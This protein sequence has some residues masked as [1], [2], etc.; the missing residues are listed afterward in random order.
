[1]EFCHKIIEVTG[2]PGSGKTTFVKAV[3]P[4]GI[5]LSG[6]MPQSYG[7]AK[8]ILCSILLSGYAVATGK[9][10]LRQLWWL[11]KRSAAYDETLFNRMNALRNSLTK[12]GHGVFTARTQET[13]VID[14]SISHIPFILGLEKAEIETFVDL[15][16]PHLSEK[17]II[18]IET[19][20]MEIL[21][22][23]LTTRGHKRLRGVYHAEAFVERNRTIAV[24]YK[25]ALLAAGLDVT[26]QEVIP[27]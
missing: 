18:F 24:Q 12:F 8:R 10:G 5:I 15:F 13:W 14:E 9:V 3:F 7:T 2:A 1:M 26:F 21:I 4:V 22:E 27:C 11:M 25:Q 6:G 16:H 23:R 19:P 17:H 20:P